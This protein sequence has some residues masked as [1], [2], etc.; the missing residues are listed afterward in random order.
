MDHDILVSRDRSK[1]YEPCGFPLANLLK[2]DDILDSNDITAPFML[3]PKFYRAL[4]HIEAGE[5]I[6][7]FDSIM[8]FEEGQLE[9][10]IEKAKENK[11]QLL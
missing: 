3:E 2:R 11:T 7:D 10:F 6:Y 5:T 1:T 9:K 4:E 8:Q